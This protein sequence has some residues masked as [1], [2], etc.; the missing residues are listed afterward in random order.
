M[1]PK[2]DEKQDLADKSREISKQD[3]ILVDIKQSNNEHKYHLLPI[4]NSNQIQESI[5]EYCSKSN[6]S[7]NRDPLEVQKY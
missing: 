6:V 2:E 4:N 5:L 7:Q 1:N 3:D